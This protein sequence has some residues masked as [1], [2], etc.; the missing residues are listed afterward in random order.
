[1]PLVHRR[2]T[3][4][5]RRWH[6]SPSCCAYSS[7]A[8]RTLLR[9]LMLGG[10]L[11]IFQILLATIYISIA[12]SGNNETLTSY[13]LTYQG[14]IK[15]SYGVA[16][17]YWHHAINHTFP[18]P[19]AMQWARF[20]ASNESC[21]DLAAAHPEPYTSFYHATGRPPDVSTRASVQETAAN[22]ISSMKTWQW[23][24]LGSHHMWQAQHGWCGHAACSAPS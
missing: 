9:V 24:P 16:E 10:C 3:T 1:M 23:R 21:R 15:S 13:Y 14:R 7:L 19:T 5:K 6:P 12:A 4:S 22:C 17:G 20:R 18:V 2:G 11:L 8:P